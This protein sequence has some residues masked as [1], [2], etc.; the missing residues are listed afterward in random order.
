MYSWILVFLLCSWKIETLFLKW[1]K[2]KVTDYAALIDMSTRL[3]NFIQKQLTWF[4]N[5]FWPNIYPTS[6]HFKIHVIIYY[7]D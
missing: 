5:L 6:W 2:S 4:W 7:S 3:Y 1:K